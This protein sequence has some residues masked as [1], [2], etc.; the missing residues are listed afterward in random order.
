[1]TYRDDFRE[2]ERE[3]W[4][5]LPRVLIAGLVLMIVLYGVGFLATGGDLAIYRFWAPKQENARRQVFQNT[6]SYVQGKIQNLE[7]ECFAFHGAEGTQKNAL[8]S[9]IRNE[10]STIDL[11]KLPVDERACVSE[12]RGQ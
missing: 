10:A 12:A 6:Q 7:Q 1:M 8:A 3:G 9:E 4:W 2:V 5:S 11:D